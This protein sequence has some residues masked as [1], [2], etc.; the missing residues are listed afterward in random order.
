[1]HKAA[2]GNA[3]GL[4]LAANGKVST[5]C[6]QTGVEF[7]RSSVAAWHAVAHDADPFAFLAPE[8]ALAEA[9]EAG[10]PCVHPRVTGKTHLFERVKPAPV[11]AHQCLNC[12]EPVTVEE[13]AR[14]RVRA[15]A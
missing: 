8:Y 2:N 4:E 13:V 3:G 7:E 14:R 10:P 6:N 5:S 12:G 1:M 11:L 15:C 9:P